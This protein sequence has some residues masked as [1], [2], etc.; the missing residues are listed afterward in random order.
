MALDFTLNTYTN[1]QQV[2]N[3]G[4]AALRWA[5]IPLYDYGRHVQYVSKEKQIGFLKVLHQICL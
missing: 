5:Q 2:I 3:W 4:M 1:M